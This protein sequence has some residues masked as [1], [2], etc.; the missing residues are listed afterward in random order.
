MLLSQLDVHVSLHLT[1]P[2]DDE[3]ADD[4]VVVADFTQEDKITGKENN[5]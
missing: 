4:L 2:E 5:A 3:P 1:I